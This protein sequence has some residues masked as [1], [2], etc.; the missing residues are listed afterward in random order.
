M[1]VCFQVVCKGA[2]EDLV[3]HSD[4]YAGHYKQHAA[5]GF[6]PILLSARE[7]WR[8]HHQYSDG[9]NHDSEDDD[10]PKLP[11]FDSGCNMKQL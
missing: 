8:H 5:A 6:M 10:L 1:P 9:V 11:G 3:A 7:W 2:C 4:Q